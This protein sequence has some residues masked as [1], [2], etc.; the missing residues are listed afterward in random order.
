ML[1]CRICGRK[2]DSFS[3]LKDHHSTTHSNQ[4]FVPP[5]AVVTRGVVVAIIIVLIAVSGIVAYL[6]YAQ[7]VQNGSNSGLLNKAISPS[8]FNEMTNVS[9]STLQAVGNNQSGVTAPSAVSTSPSSQLVYGGRP[10]VLFIGAEW[11]PYCAA[12][13]WSLVIALSKFGNFTG[14]LEYMQSAVSDGDISTV[15][16]LNVT[17][18]SPYVSFVP[19]EHEDRNHNILQDVTTDQLNLWDSYGSGNYPFIDIDAQYVLT[20]GQINPTDLSGLNWTQ[21]GSVLD[22]PSNSVAKV[23]D[24]AANQLIGAIC[25][26]LQSRNWPEPHSVCSQP[27]ANISYNGDSSGNQT[28]VDPNLLSNSSLQTGSMQ[29]YFMVV[30]FLPRLKY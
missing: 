20:G 2:F 21:I 11:C 23:I 10:E 18:A 9:D 24:G 30:K 14:S 1:K 16:F 12:E 13:R 3:S 7:A 4:R 15:T 25:V 17:Y 28:N 5:R 26:S 8:L 22:D 19:V 6:I 29:P 27:F